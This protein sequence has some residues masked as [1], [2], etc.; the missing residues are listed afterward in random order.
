MP[1]QVRMAVLAIATIMA[2]G[3]LSLAQYHDGDDD[4][5]YQNDLRQARHYGY[6]QGY[7]D[8]VT[9]GRHEGRENDPNDHQDPNW[10]QSTRGYEQWMG[11]IEDFQDGY[12][13]GYQ[14]GF[15]SGYRSMNGGWRDPDRDMDEPPYNRGGYVYD[16]SGYG[17]A[18]N[19][20]YRIGLQDGMSQAREDTFKNKPFNANPRGKY[21]DRDH[22]YRREYGDKNS[23]RAEYTDGYRAG[24]ESAFRRY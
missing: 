17:S 4:G 19:M 8:G 22:G 16:Q 9:K 15:R 13:A 21:D 23:Y 2:L 7:R 10:R 20:G 18:G 3:G 5:Y 24:Y 11:P 1:R 14:N 6:Q 12:R